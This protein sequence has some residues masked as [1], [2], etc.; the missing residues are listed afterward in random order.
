MGMHVPASSEARSLARKATNSATSSGR[1]KLPRGSFGQPQEVAEL[2][3]FLA[4][5]RASLLAGACI[6]I[7]GGQ[8]HS[9]L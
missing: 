7:D 4:S 1:P 9:N 5:D 6:P 8:G 2:V 3:A